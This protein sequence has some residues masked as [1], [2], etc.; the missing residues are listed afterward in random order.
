M[1]QEKIIELKENIILQAN[2]VEKMIEHCISGFIEKNKGTLKKVIDT[3]EV[4]INRNEIRIDEMYTSILALYHAEAK[5]LRTILMISKM[6]IDLERVADQCVNFAESAIFLIDRPMVKPLV[7][8]PRMAELAKK[9]LNDSINAFTNED[10]KLA[11]NVCR[12]DEEIDNLNE[13]IVRELLTYMIEDPKT[14]ER[15]HHLIRIAHNIE[16]IADLSTNIAEEVV[17]IAEG[18]DIKHHKFNRR[19]K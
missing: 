16:K 10:A 1:I 14:I 13:Q 15:S 18:K 19:K 3:E 12:R 11:E 4:R 7:D 8:I 6:N 9:M 17:F 2:D 5:E